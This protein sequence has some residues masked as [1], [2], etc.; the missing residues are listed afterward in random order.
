MTL[1]LSI[2]K[3]E[4][5]SPCVLNIFYKIRNDSFESLRRH[6]ILSTKNANNTTINN[7]GE[8]WEPCYI[9]L[10]KTPVAY[11]E[12]NLQSGEVKVKSICVE[13]K[14][15]RKGVLKWIVNYLSS[16]YNRPISLW[17]VTNTGNQEIFLK[18]GFVIE[19]EEI[20]SLF[21]T[22]TGGCVIEA[23]MVRRSVQI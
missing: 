8:L 15:R 3:R 16:S 13:M 2:L 6:Y 1:E 5:L 23:K 7:E 17:C 4:L 12:Y 21:I 20:S 18:L 10:R 19:K 22:P 14:H 11:F 9:L